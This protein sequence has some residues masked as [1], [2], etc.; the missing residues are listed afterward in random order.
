MQKL[1]INKVLAILGGLRGESEL[2]II[3]DCFSRNLSPDNA[4]Q[5]VINNR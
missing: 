3:K 4:A 5:V 1:Y 2:D